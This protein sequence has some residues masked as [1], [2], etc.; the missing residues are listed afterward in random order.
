MAIKVLSCSSVLPK[1]ILTNV[2]LEKIVDTTD[3]WI[4]K[5]T[6]IKERRVLGEDESYLECAVQTAKQAVE[7][8]KIDP[9]EIGLIIN[10][11]STPAQ[12]MP[13]TASII[14]GRL[15]IKNCISF[16]LQ[17][18][19]SGFVYAMATA[20]YFMQS[21]SS[22]RYALVMGCEAL[23]KVVNWQD[24]STCV[25]FGDG[26]SGVILQ[27]DDSQTDTGI[28]YCDLGGDGAGKNSLEIP[29][30]VGQGY[31]KLDDAKGYL[32]MNGREVFKNSV[33]YFTAL[34]EKTMKLNHLDINDIDWIIPHQANVRIIQ[35]VAEYS[36]IP[37]EKFVITLNKHG[38]TSAA[39]I[40]LALSEMVQTDKI[41]SGDMVMLVGFGAGYTWGTVLLRM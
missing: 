29:W 27:R 9:V 7:N 5:M 8:A 14:Q 35:S 3:E 6:G 1:K 17:A 24:R 20:Y 23:S 13:S 10:G 11:T 12:V 40:P 38:N 18:A 28:V 32:A 21:N 34:I 4:T 26:F 2:D 36:N 37:M 30:G 39:S 31:K 19:C 25:L 41:K 33:N 15:G 22:I 16:D